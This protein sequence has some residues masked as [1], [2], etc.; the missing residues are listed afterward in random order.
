MS[1]LNQELDT[2]LLD[3]FT[4]VMRTAVEENNGTIGLFAERAKKVRV[5]SVEQIEAYINQN[6]TKRR[7]T[8]SHE[9]AMDFVE[10]EILSKQ[11]QPKTVRIS[12]TELMNDPVYCL[13]EVRVDNERENK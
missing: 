9:E 2:I 7:K 1:N 12:R 6:Y 13:T 3:Y 10:R 4:E 8:I 11:Y 5:K